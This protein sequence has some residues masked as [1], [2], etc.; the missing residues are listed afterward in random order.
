MNNKLNEELNHKI[1][2]D[3]SELMK[4]AGERFYGMPESIAEYYKQKEEEIHKMEKNIQ[5]SNK[6]SV[7]NEKLLTDTYLT[8]GT[9]L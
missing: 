9:H 6:L 2:A 3:Y 8:L 7:I 1:S 5:S 4:K